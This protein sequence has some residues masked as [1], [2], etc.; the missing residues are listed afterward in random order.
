MVGVRVPRG[1]RR[2]R[3]PAVVEQAEQAPPEED[4]ESKEP[5]GQ[6]DE[7]ASDPPTSSS[8]STSKKDESVE[9]MSLPGESETGGSGNGSAGSRDILAENVGVGE[10]GSAALESSPKF[11]K[12]GESR[13]AHVSFMVCAG[14]EMT[15]MIRL[16]R[17][18]FRKSLKS[19]IK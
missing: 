10:E 13:V 11:R 7:A 4:R 18:Q 8:S 1:G 3:L 16:S 12:L 15:C 14:L 17:L 6:G 5:S 9:S 19:M 2:I